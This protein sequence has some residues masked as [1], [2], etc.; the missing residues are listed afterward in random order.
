MLRTWKEIEN[1]NQGVDK[2]RK[3]S[4]NVIFDIDQAQE[5]LKE[6]EEELRRTLV[7]RRQLIIVQLQ[8]ELEGGASL[9]GLWCSGTPLMLVEHRLMKWP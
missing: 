7:S 5:I 3:T 4:S 1:L 6:L 2:D 9:Y 8:A